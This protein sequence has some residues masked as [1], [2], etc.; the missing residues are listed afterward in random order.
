MNTL[1]VTNVETLEYLHIQTEYI[2]FNLFI[3][4]C[5]FLAPDLNIGVPLAGVTVVP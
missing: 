3:H 5:N 1:T 4:S 2:N